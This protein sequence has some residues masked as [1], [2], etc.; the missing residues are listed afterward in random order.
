MKKQVQKLRNESE[1]IRLACQ[2]LEET[3]SEERKNQ[4]KIIEEERMR[5]LEEIGQLTEN[6]KHEM[7]ERKL[8]LSI[9][10]YLNF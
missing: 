6:H 8:N 1:E 9:L 3:L 2:H 10:Y 4:T 5:F 7:I